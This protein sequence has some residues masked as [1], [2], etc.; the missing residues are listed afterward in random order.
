MTSK[1][2]GFLK[3]HPFYT[4]SCISEY[5]LLSEEILEKYQYV[6]N[7]E[8]VGQNEKM[9]WSTKLIDEFFQDLTKE[10]GK[11]S[12]TFCL[13]PTL[14]WTVDFIKRYLLYWDWEGL[15]ENEVVKKHKGILA[16]FHNELD[17]IIRSLQPSRSP[18]ELLIH[19][20]A[21]WN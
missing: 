18:S 12:V 17:P 3:Q 2:Y 15:A 7:W 10:T 5:Y 16:A 8:L 14:P 13:N 4:F 21:H 9:E 19:S 20:A 6:L 11:F 1:Q